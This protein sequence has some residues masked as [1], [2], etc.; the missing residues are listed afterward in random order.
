L[1]NDTAQ[2]WYVGTTPVAYGTSYTFYVGG[3]VA[4]TY[5]TTAV[6]ENVS[7]AMVSDNN[8][9]K[10]GKAYY[11]ATMEDAGYTI[12]E[13]GF[14]YGRELGAVE[15]TLENVGEKG[16][17]GYLVKKGVSDPSAKQFALSY[18]CS[19]PVTGTTSSSARAYVVYVDNNGENQVAYS[20]VATY[21]Y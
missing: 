20:A 4:V 5:D 2:T 14:I 15:L 9:E 19:N 1:S 17:A 13:H 10:G 8:T 7:V 11:L 6:T 18:G 16:D 12:V 21:A 3:P